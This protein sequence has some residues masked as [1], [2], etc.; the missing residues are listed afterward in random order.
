M[1]LLSKK[2]RMWVTPVACHLDHQ[3]LELFVPSNTERLIV[4]LQSGVVAYIVCQYLHGRFRLFQ[5]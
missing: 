5:E 3:G 4:M 1:A 2:A